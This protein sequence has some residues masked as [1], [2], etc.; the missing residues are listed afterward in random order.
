M[1]FSKV[2]LVILIISGALMGCGGEE[3][4]TTIPTETPTEVIGGNNTQPE[5]S[6]GPGSVTNMS[7]IIGSTHDLDSVSNAYQIDYYSY[8]IEFEEKK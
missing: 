2:S 1:K 8:A 5:I 3:I 4:A 7:Q 6:N